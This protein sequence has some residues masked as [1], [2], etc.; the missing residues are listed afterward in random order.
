MA[1]HSFS[2]RFYQLLRSRRRSHNRGFTLTELLVSIIISALIVSGLLYL[3]VE[4]LEND[5]RESARNETQREMQLAMNYIATDL[6]EAVYV[7]D[8]I[9]SNRTLGSA[10]I[11]PVKNFLPNFGANTTPVLAFWKPVYFDSDVL[12]GIT[13]NANDDACRTFL[14]RRSAYSLVI[15]LQE[16]NPADPW[17]GESIIRRY[18][19]PQYSNVAAL[20][21]SDGYVSPTGEVTFQ[22]WPFNSNGIN[23]QDEAPTS[24]NS[25]VLVDF[26]A[27]P[28]VGTSKACEDPVSYTRSPANSTSFYACVRDGDPDP[29]SGDVLNTNQDVFV[30]LQGDVS[31]RRG[32]SSRGFDASSRLPTLQSQVLVGGVINKDVPQ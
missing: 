3:V 4:L 19:L 28:T 31:G 30:F 27:D 25:P 10:T 32:G 18:E 12:D 14:V 22:N 7:Y 13:C 16:A 5:A 9:T 29:N 1:S 11:A 8:D 23:L 20:T 2:L 26:V 15:Y 24:G 21:E 6:R 17:S